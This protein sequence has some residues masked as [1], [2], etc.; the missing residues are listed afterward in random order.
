MQK[1]EWRSRAGGHV[2]GARRKVQGAKWLGTAI[3]LA[4]ALLVGCEPSVEDY[5]PEPNVYCV[6]RAGSDTLRLLAGMTLPFKDSVP[7]SPDWNGVAGVQGVVRGRA[8]EVALAAKPD[9][10]GLYQYVGLS[11]QPGETLELEA[12]Y[13]TGEV[14]RGITGVPG[15]F[16]IEHVSA[17]TVLEVPW[18]GD[19]WQ[20]LRIEYSWATSRHA[21][22]YTTRLTTYYSNA[23][24]VITWSWTNDWLAG[25]S[26]SIRVA[27]YAYY[28]GRGFEPDSAGIDSV[29][30]GVDAL[31]RNLDDYR[32]FGWWQGGG[33]RELLHLD[34]GLGV[35]G[36]RTAS[37]DTVVRLAGQARV[38]SGVRRR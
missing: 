5:V 17:D 24:T 10:V 8:G 14:V 31:D 36:S 28:E 9:S 20:T 34:G 2:Q 25:R 32:R 30:I 15:S 22:R 38:D 19:S 26:D 7:Q 33:N 13:P 35:F 6:A 12:R 29:R 21:A 23:D 4:A 11:P 18:P 1:A 37:P 27:F 3:V 16:R